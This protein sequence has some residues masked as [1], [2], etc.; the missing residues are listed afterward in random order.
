MMQILGLFIILMLLESGNLCCKAQ[1]YLSCHESGC[2]KQLQ[3]TNIFGHF[4]NRFSFYPDP[5]HYFNLF[6][7]TCLPDI[8]SFGETDNKALEEVWYRSAVLH[9]QLDS[10]AFVFSVPFDAGN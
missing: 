2:K 5:S 6:D 9:H 10:E 3:V 7:F 4:K 1:D 8:R